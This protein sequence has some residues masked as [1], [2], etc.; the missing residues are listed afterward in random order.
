LVRQGLI[1]IVSLFAAGSGPAEEP[2]GIDF[3]PRSLPP[4]GGAWTILVTAPDSLQ[5][6][7]IGVRIGDETVWD[8][9]SWKTL[10][11]GSIWDLVLPSLSM[12]SGPHAVV[13]RIGDELRELGVVPVRMPP[14]LPDSAV[15]SDRVEVFLQ[16]DVLLYE[17]GRRRRPMVDV[18]VLSEPFSLLLARL[19]V[20]M[21]EKVAWRAAEADSL[22]SL[23]AGDATVWLSPRARR[24][25]RL[26]FGSAGHAVEAMA[27]ILAGAAEVVDAKPIRRDVQRIRD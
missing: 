22:Q 4:E 15:Y 9:A 21:I 10:A 8:H 5:P 6:R 25:Y 19:D 17:P 13:A 12:G 24:S 20:V 18:P 27:R 7:S 2:L 23:G 14:S 1:A 26:L 3:S 16:P 11:G